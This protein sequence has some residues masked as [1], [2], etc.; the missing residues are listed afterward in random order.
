MP[1][2]DRLSNA[3]FQVP[4][5]NWMVWAR[6]NY[7]VVRALL[8]SLSARTAR[9]SRQQKTVCVQMRSSGNPEKGGP[10]DGLRGIAAIARRASVSCS[11]QIQPFPSRGDTGDHPLHVPRNFRDLHLTPKQDPLETGTPDVGFDE[12]YVQL[13][14]LDHNV[15]HQPWRLARRMSRLSTEPC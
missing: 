11:V 1:T 8:P 15:R 5:Q 13:L 9:L 10:C 14:S 2:A 7:P 4:I 3:I 6:Q 12:P